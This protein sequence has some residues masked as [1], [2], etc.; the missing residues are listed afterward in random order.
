MPRIPIRKELKNSRLLSSYGSWIYCTNCNKTV[1][2]L[3]YVTYDSF[4]F[5][6]T[7]KCGK[8]GSI[9]IAFND[10]SGAGQSNKALVKIKNRQCCPNDDSS[11]ITFV[12]K[13]LEKYQ[14]EIVCKS[15][16]HLY[17]GGKPVLSLD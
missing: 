12:D 7:C 10:T 9:D 17:K 3:C 11:L 8:T 1:A 4:K 13:N 16:N 6:F 5:Q 2:Y 15:C 14:Y